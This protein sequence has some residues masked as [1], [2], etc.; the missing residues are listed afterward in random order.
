MGYAP[1]DGDDAVKQRVGG[2]GLGQGGAHISGTAR[3]HAVHESGVALALPS[4]RSLAERRVMLDC[5]GMARILRVMSPDGH[6]PALGRSGRRLGVRVPPSSLADITPDSAGKVSPGGGG[7]SVARR[8]EDL[9]M[10]RVPVRFRRIAPDAR[11]NDGDRIW[12]HG[13]GAFV[14]C[15]VANGLVLRPD[16]RRSGHGFVE[17]ESTVPLQRYEEDLA[18]T[19]REWSIDEPRVD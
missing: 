8:L 11:G 14:A 10:H 7:M 1:Q 6:Q 19:A 3:G 15:S 13:D 17:P 18:A 4:R 16:E 5:I 2:G 9:P 12:G